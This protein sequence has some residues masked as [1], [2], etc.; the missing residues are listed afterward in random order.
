MKKN[1]L[2]ITQ[3]ILN[4]LDSDIVNSIDDTV[5]SQQVAAI[6]KACYNEMISNRN[7]PHLKK[8][9]QL[10]ALG[11]V[12]KPNYLMVPETLKELITFSYEC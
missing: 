3:A 8:L 11:D 9:L 10:D 4:D 6:I 2:E 5:E 7:W 12:T 1:L